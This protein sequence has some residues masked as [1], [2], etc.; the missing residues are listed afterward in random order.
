LSKSDDL[1]VKTCVLDKHKLFLIISMRNDK[2]CRYPAATLI[3]MIASRLLNML[4]SDLDI[5]RYVAF[6]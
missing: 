3:D 2:M 6:I 5:S 4:A 1:R